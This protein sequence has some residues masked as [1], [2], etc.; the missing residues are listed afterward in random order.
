MAQRTTKSQVNGYRFLF[1]RVE[2]AL[3][4]RDVRMIHDPMNGHMRS[5]LAGSL[6]A[7]IIILGALALSFISPTG[8]VGDAKIVLDKQNG[9]L[10]VAING[11]MHPALNLASARLAA[12][13][14][15]KARPVNASALDNYDRGPAIGI[16]NAP[17][18]LDALG[19]GEDS[20]WAVCDKRSNPTSATADSQI[21]VIG[22]KIIANRDSKALDRSEALY[23]TYKAK[24]YLV[25]NG[26]SAEVDPQSFAVR[27]VFGLADVKPRGVSSA[28]IAAIPPAPEIKA[29]VI[30]KVGD[31][32]PWKLAGA[33][34]GSILRDSGLSGTKFYVVLG[35]G[36]QE[37]PELTAN[38]VRYASNSKVV[39]ISPSAIANVPRTDALPIG[40]YPA[41]RP[42]IV[43]T[44]ESTV[45][46]FDWHRRRDGETTTAIYR[47]SDYPAP[48]GAQPVPVLSPAR[49]GSTASI[50]YIPPGS[51]YAIRTTGST[52][53]TTRRD[54]YFLVTDVG[55]RYGIPDTSIEPLGL[56][57]PMTAPWA[58]ISLLPPGP[59]L[60]RAAALV[61]R[62]NIDPG[63][64]KPVG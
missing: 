42:T 44:D 60:D 22:G 24:N 5:Y 53:N 40:T 12:N 38:L 4:R 19:D 2:H 34:I 6:F 29:P 27:E 55:V 14:P 58:I 9:I 31:P 1:R 33:V 54:S 61:A 26:T 63:P 43:S 25:M 50:V 10:Y 20:N 51:T 37:V 39:D 7:V 21:A 32:V 13:S 3:V 59:T 48:T 36:I 30:E 11:R 28:L 41:D 18:S 64:G 47:G 17:A 35:S 46:C 23:V 56:P 57:E 52:A 8:S 15:E 49:D 62:D 45:V 16:P